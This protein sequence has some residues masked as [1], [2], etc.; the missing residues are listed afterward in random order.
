MR[1]SAW[2]IVCAVL[3]AAYLMTGIKVVFMLKFIRDKIKTVDDKQNRA[4]R[5][6][7]PVRVK[8]RTVCMY[9]KPRAKGGDK[10]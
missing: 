9:L 10:Q 7:I 2:K 5:G 6:R 3:S 4:K 1:G 8:I